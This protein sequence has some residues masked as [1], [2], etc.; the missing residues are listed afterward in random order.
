[1]AS[2]KLR[3]WKVSFVNGK[4]LEFDRPS[5]HEDIMMDA[6]EVM[7]FLMKEGFTQRDLNYV[8]LLDQEGE[9]TND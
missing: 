4:E 2:S 3:K 8:M 7:D 5:L 9:N 1:M 6:D